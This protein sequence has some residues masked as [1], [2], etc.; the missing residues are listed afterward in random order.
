[1][2]A[3]MNNKAQEKA[4]KA[5]KPE[6]ADKDEKKEVDKKNG[7]KKEEKPAG[8]GMAKSPTA[9]GGKDLAS[10]DSKSKVRHIHI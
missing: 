1:M 10:P 7:D 5:D 3:E 8:K 2:N 4:E 6:K 9:G